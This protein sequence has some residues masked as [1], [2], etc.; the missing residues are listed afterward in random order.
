M[1]KLPVDGSVRSPW[2]L[3]VSEAVSQVGDL[4][5]TQETDPDP[6]WCCEAGRQTE[7]LQHGDQT[8][9][10]QRADGCL[11]QRLP[12]GT[13]AIHNAQHRHYKGQ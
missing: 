9:R 3:E 11:K 4:L 12:P 5:H 2:Q 7:V 6:C 1:I 10:Q 13:A 8:D